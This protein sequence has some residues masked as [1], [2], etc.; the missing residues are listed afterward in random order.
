MLRDGY[1]HGTAISTGPLI[2]RDR[3]R[4]GAATTRPVLRYRYY[5]ETALRDRYYG[6]VN[7]TGPLLPRGRYCGTGTTVPLLSRGAILNRTHGTPKNLH[8]SVFL[9]NVFGPICY[10]PP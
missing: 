4:H 6:T 3:Y 5:Y 2:L 8:I 7:T 10:G 1:Y 9:L